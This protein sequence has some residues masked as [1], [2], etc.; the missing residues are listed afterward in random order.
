MFPYLFIIYCYVK[1]MKM[2]M[3]AMSQ[4]FMCASTRALS[5]NSDVIDIIIFSVSYILCTN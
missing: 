1:A 4:S 2:V 3:Q 5:C